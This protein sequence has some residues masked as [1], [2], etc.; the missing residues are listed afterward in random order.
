[1]HV[2]VALGVNLR[3]VCR[4]LRTIVSLCIPSRVG[5]VVL[6]IVAVQL[7]DVQTSSSVVGAQ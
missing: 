7:L 6:L 5:H 2:V 4:R 1:M 3:K